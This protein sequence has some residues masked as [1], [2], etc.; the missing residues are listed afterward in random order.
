MDEAQN[1][2]FEP[3]P[4]RN[5]MITSISPL[6]VSWIG[7]SGDSPEPWNDACPAKAACLLRPKEMRPSWVILVSRDRA[8]SLILALL[9]AS[10]NGPRASRPLRLPSMTAES[11]WL[12]FLR[13]ISPRRFLI[14][15]STFAGSSV[16]LTVVLTVISTSVIALRASPKSR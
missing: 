16:G 5:P 2:L 4:Q 10:L 14:A 15:V 3:E 11:P 13:G 1:R 7:P 6:M 12:S 8:A 9:R